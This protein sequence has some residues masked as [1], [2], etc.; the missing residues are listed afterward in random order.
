MNRHS[1]E[2]LLQQDAAPAPEQAA[3]QA[4]RQAALAEYARVHAAAANEPVVPRTSVFKALLGALRLSREP[5]SR[6]RD[7]MPWYSRRMLLGGAASVCLLVVSGTL[8]WKTMK[9]YPEVARL[10]PQEPVPAVTAEEHAVRSARC[11]R[12]AD[13]K[14]NPT[15]WR[16]DEA[17][18]AEQSSRDAEASALQKSEEE[19]AAK[20]AS[21]RQ[22]PRAPLGAKVMR[23]S[24]A[25][26]RKW[27]VKRKRSR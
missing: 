7:V 26:A 4:A 22:E 18:L 10:E 24:S 15:I 12:R 3:R 20:S 14:A 16:A 9:V 23:R 5:Q 27:T 8:V 2:K 6:G 1:F 11:P 13:D 21:P 17:F 25:G 19:Q